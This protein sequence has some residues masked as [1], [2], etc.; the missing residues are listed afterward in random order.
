MTHNFI[1]L[2]TLPTPLSSKQVLNARI[3][4]EQLFA[5]EEAPPRLEEK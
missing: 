5:A 2:L 1:P 4:L 3:I